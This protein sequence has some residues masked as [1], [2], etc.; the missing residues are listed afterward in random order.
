M[1]NVSSFN[2]TNTGLLLQPPGGFFAL[3]WRTATARIAM[4]NIAKAEFGV[5]SA[6]VSVVVEVIVNVLV[7]VLASV[8]EVLASLVVEV[9]ANDVVEV[10]ASVVVEVLTVTS[11]GQMN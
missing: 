11:C 6:V 9:L 2:S 4:I 8:V 1:L 3:F 7:E 5:A 10:L